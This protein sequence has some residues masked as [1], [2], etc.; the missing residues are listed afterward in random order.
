MLLERSRLNDLKDTNRQQP[1][2]KEEKIRRSG[3][4][5]PGMVLVEESTGAKTVNLVRDTDT[6]YCRS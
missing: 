6:Q 1:G 5:E 2:K 4:L 3:I